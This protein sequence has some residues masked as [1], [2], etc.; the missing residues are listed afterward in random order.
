MSEYIRENGRLNVHIVPKILRIGA[1][2]TV[3]GNFALLGK[4]PTW[5]LKYKHWI[6]IKT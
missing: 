4:G 2:I 6:K 3:T 1:I 5:L